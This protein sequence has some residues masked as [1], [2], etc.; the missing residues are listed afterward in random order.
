MFIEYINLCMCAIASRYRICWGLSKFLDRFYT[1]TTKGYMFL[2]GF[3]F[4]AFT[5]VNFYYFRTYN[6]KIDVFIFGLKDDDT[7]AV[8]TILWQ[9]YPILIAL[10]CSLIFGFV[11]VMF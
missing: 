8:L 5:I 4:M 7:L 10:F 9:D 1:I 2:C 3:V 11:C 6:N